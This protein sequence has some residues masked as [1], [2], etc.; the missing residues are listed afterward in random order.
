MLNISDGNVGREFGRRPLLPVVKFMVAAA[1][2]LRLLE[3]WVRRAAARA[4]M[5]AG[6]IKEASTAMIEIT[7]NSSIRVK[8]LRREAVRGARLVM[9]LVMWITPGL[10]VCEDLPHLNSSARGTFG[11]NAWESAIKIREE[12]ERPACFDV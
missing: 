12:S 7:T 6:M 5:M 3:H 11:K 10:L 1:S 9:V 2:C 4:F 8:P